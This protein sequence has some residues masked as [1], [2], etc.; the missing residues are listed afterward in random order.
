M[1][2][3]ERASVAAEQR[4]SQMSVASIYMHCKGPLNVKAVMLHLRMRFV[5][6]KG[7]LHPDQATD[8]QLRSLDLGEFDLERH[9]DRGES[10]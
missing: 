8:V 2:L 6:L 9:H 5:V 1:G 3:R 4:V 7:L 10:G